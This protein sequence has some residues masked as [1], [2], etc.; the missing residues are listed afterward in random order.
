MLLEETG[1]NTAMYTG[2]IE[3]TALNQLNVGKSATYD[4]LATIDDE[5]TIIVPTDLTDEDAVRVDYLDTDGEGIATQIGDQVD[6]PTHSGIVSFDGSNYKVAD[7][8]TVTLTDAD[9]NTNSDT[10]EVYTLAADTE[11]GDRIGEKGT[12][13]SQSGRLLDITF[14]DATWTNMGC[15][16]SDDGLSSTGFTLSET[17]STSGIFTGTF[18]IPANYCTSNVTVSTTTGKDLE[19]NYVDY[20]DASGELIE[21]GDSAGI[22]ANTGSVSFDRSYT[23]YHLIHPITIHRK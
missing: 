16:V 7:T 14:D 15:G 18:Q 22:S 2:S 5:I 10:T 1:D 11:Y 4:G 13:V 21:V 19:V 12:E 3:Y 9:L 6:A 8:V 23:L 17:T 20:S